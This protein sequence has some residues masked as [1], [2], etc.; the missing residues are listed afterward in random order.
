MSHDFNI[1]LAVFHQYKI[2]KIWLVKAQ[3]HTMFG[4]VIL[5][6]RQINIKLSLLPQIK[7]IFC[8]QSRLML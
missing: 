7:F 4:R 5:N 1:F 3:K 8:A 6:R 2:T